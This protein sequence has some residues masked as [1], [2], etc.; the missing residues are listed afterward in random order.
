MKRTG[1][2]RTRTAVV[3]PARLASKRL[4]RKLLLAETSKY[5]LQHTYE[6][7][8]K[9]K[10]AGEVVIACDSEEIASACREFGAP[11]VMT[12]PGL[13]SGTDRV[14][15]ALSAVKAGIV[16]NLQADEPEIDPHDLD[17]LVAAMEENRAVSMT[18]LSV[19]IE[20]A[21]AAKTL[22]DPDTVK[23]VVD[24][25]GFALYFSRAAIPFPRDGGLG[26]KFE[27]RKHVGVYAYRRRFL[28]EFASWPP[29]PLEEIE[30]LEQL[31]ALENGARVKVVPARCDSTGIDTRADYEE[32]VRRYTGKIIGKNRSR[33]RSGRGRKGATRK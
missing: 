25:D 14:A 4:P 28:R 18:T 10:S 22:K 1:K 16:V 31:R 32:F 26:G 29:S 17:A 20:G 30:R 11:Y 33:G 13:P 12:D 9:A 19:A 15:A 2:R 3:I 24:T 27:T 23:V 7:A 5:L 6:Q 8:V 21:R